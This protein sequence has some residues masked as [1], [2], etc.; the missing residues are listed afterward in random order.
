MLELIDNQGRAVLLDAGPFVLINLYGPAVTNMDNERFAYKLA[1]YQVSLLQTLWSAARRQP[2]RMSCVCDPDTLASV[3]CLVLGSTAGGRG[4]G[5]LPGRSRCRACRSVC[6]AA[7]QQQG[8]GSGWHGM[9]CLPLHSIQPAVSA[10]RNSLPFPQ[11]LGAHGTLTAA[12][13]DVLSFSG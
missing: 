5:E 11:E 6:C 12:D 2:A 13:T 9:D 8:S 7:A 4:R 3:L 10:A 1:L